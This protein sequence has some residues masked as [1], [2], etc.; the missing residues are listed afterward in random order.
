MKAT[1]FRSSARIALL[2]FFGIAIPSCS[3]LN[4]GHVN[5][6]RDAQ[7]RFT[8]LAALENS[9]SLS[10][11]IPTGG[12]S[13]ATG[14]QGT[15]VQ[16]LSPV[17]P[18]GKMQELQRG[19]GEIYEGL[20]ALNTRAET[21]LKEDKLLGSSLTLSVL[22]RWRSL[23]YGH[24]IR[25]QET[26]TAEGPGIDKEGKP[27]PLPPSLSSVVSLADTTLK[28]LEAEKVELFPRD[29]F[30]LSAMDPLVRY[31]IAYIRAS[32]AFLLKDLGKEQDAEK[33]KAR[34]AALEKNII[35]RIDEIVKAEDRLRG[36]SSGA[37]VQ[38]ERYVFLSRLMI[39]R[40]GR[41]L[42]ILTL[43]PAARKEKLPSFIS[44][45]ERLHKD[46]AESK[47]LQSSLRQTQEK[48]KEIL[49]PLSD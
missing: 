5:A 12:D 38:I 47:S 49:K 17:I 48:L 16:V 28:R 45:I 22:A 7:N 21:Y 9:Y 10:T 15:D 4:L 24:L 40:T 32:G 42:A 14:T 1:L 36:V 25:V 34:L 35:E 37:S 23:F 46:Y 11:V 13:A 44:S 30:L 19:Y 33:E 6:L 43:D 39:L 2:S 41:T 18:L 8:E 3:I 27:D 26:A 29:R 20:N 31:D